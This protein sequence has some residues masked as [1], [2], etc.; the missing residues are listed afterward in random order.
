VLTA[1]DLEGVASGGELT[2]APGTLVT[3]LARE[4]AERRNITLREVEPRRGDS[5]R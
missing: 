1:Q 2:I 4:E 3:P 5:D